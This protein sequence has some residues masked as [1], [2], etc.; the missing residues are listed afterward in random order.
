MQRHL[1]LEVRCS[2]FIT[3]AVD[4][5]SPLTRQGVIALLRDYLQQPEIG[6]EYLID[7]VRLEE[8]RDTGD[9]MLNDSPG[10]SA[11]MDLIEAGLIQ[12]DATG[13]W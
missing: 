13:L 7:H 6:F 9:R 2:A 1:V 5:S 8:V 11:V 4:K 12:E 10:Q 3:A